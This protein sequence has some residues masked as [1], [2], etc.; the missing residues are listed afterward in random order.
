MDNTQIDLTK[1]IQAS[2]TDHR[3]D[4]V[5][6][7][8][9]L[10]LNVYSIDMP[11][12]QSGDIK[13]DP[14]TGQTYIEVNRNHPITRQRFTVA[15]EVAHYVKHPRVLEKRGQ[16]DRN[17]TF[18]NAK[19]IKLENEADK[20]AAAI[21]MPEYLV[22]DYFKTR[23]WSKVTKFDTD[24]LSEIAESFRV[25]RAMAITRLRELGFPISYMSFA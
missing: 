3:I 14:S 2:Q 5:G 16:L 18:K 1:L 11:D 25:S 7:A 6:L 10:G 12:N 15:H 9:K 13:K 19:E 22:D 8:K 17:D 23:S 4:V 24:M 20:E 21:L